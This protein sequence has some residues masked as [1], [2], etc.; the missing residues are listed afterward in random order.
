V[1]TDS[2]VALIALVDCAL[3]GNLECMALSEN[4]RVWHESALSNTR[5]PDDFTAALQL[6]LAK[7]HASRG[8]ADAAVDYARRAGASSPDNLA[9]RLQEATLYALLER[10]DDLGEVLDDV[11]SRFPLR[12][13]SDATFRL[14]QAR[15]AQAR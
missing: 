9:Y 14:L 8:E 12:S 6:S 2:I 15:L 11:G 5:L 10:W 7:I 13:K 3:N 1:P 4:T